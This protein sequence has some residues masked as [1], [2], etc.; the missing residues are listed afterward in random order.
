MV[1]TWLAEEEKA[2]ARA[3]S[4]LRTTPASSACWA[5]ISNPLVA[6]MTATKAKMVVL[7]TQPPWLA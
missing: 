6:P 5:G 4:V 2:V 1:A 7:V 3:R